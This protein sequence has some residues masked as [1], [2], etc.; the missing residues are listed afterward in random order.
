MPARITTEILLRNLETDE[1][2]NGSS[3]IPP[4]GSSSR[5]V[6]LSQ[7]NY[8]R[9]KPTRYLTINGSR[10]CVA[11]QEPPKLR[12]KDLL[13]NKIIEGYFLDQFEKQINIGACQISTFFNRSSRGELFH[14]YHRY[15]REDAE[16]FTLIDRISNIEYECISSMTLFMH[17][18]IK[19]NRQFFFKLNKLKSGVRSYI[20]F[21]GKILYLKGS[22]PPPKQI[23]RRSLTSKGE[24]VI[25]KKLKNN[26]SCN[27]RNHLLAKGCKK[28]RKTEEMIGCSIDFF[29]TW[30]ESQFEEGMNWNNRGKF[31]KNKV[32]SWQIDHIVPCNL[33]D[34]TKDEE[35]L[36]CFHYTNMRPLWQ[37]EN[38]ARPRDGS[39]LEPAVLIAAKRFQIEPSES[40][41]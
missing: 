18:G 27:L 35:V 14:L 24:K 34:L 16:T 39:D 20:T 29:K 9:N 40:Y 2:I 5:R 12:L 31:E 8:L 36:I 23:L 4:R 15:V 21:H 13:E 26:I 32:R 22:T 3:L 19:K 10:Y 37:E 17:L 33:F 28:T 25:L 7:L 30:L 1:V 41:Q 6:I 38:R 11:G